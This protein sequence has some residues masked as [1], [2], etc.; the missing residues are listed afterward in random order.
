MLWKEGQREVAELRGRFEEKL[1]ECERVLGERTRL[2][3]RLCE[4]EV[5][6][7]ELGLEVEEWRSG[8]RERQGA[9]VIGWGV[10]TE[11]KEQRSRG[12]QT[13]Q[14]KQKSRGVQTE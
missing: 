8:G 14:R 11:E 3:E 12:T 13:K 10:Q 4:A 7:E 6:C 1:V 5:T 2:E 9:E